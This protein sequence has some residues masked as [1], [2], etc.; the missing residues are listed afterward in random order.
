MRHQQSKMRMAGTRPAAIAAAL[1]FSEK[2]GFGQIEPPLNSFDPTIEMVEP[3]RKIG[4][5]AFKNAQTT[6][7]LAHVVPQPVHRASDV[8]Q[9]LQDDAIDLGHS[10]FHS[11]LVIS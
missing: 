1:E 3:V 5:L 7:D 10:Y 9:V 8:T 6:F 2:S 11:I 4:V